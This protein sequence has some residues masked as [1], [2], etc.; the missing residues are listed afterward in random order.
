[1]A[2][3]LVRQNWPRRR[4]TDLVELYGVA[5]GRNLEALP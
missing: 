3:S 5:E 4:G 2:S 1:M